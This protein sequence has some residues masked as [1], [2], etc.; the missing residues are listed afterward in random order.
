MSVAVKK[1]AIMAAMAARTGPPF[2]R[3][4]GK[5][6]CSGRE[7]GPLKVAPSLAA[8][9]TADHTADG[10]GVFDVAQNKIVRVLKAGSDPEN[11]DVSKDGTQLLFRTRMTRR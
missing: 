6:A 8:T 3:K 7:S 11:F 4:E 9:N 10:I 1:G 5:A 2:H